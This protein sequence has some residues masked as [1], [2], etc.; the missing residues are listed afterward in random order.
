M[1]TQAEASRLRENVERLT[2]VILPQNIKCE[3]APGLC[4]SVT[5]EGGSIAAEDLSALSRGFFLAARAVKE[6]TL[7]LNVKQ[8]RHFHSVGAMVDMSRGAVMTVGAVKRYINE[9]S[10]LGMN[11]LMLYTEDT[12]EVPEYP[13]FGYL[14]GRYT[15]DELRE[16][17]AY[18]EGMGVELVP[19][20]QTLAHLAQFLQW[21]DARKLA[22]QPDVLLADDEDVYRFIEAEI[23]AVSGCIRSRRIH[24]GMDEAH[25]IGLGR[26]MEK[27]GIQDRFSILNRHLNRVMEI[28]RK[29]HYEP[30]MWSD[31]FFRLGSKINDYYDMEA[32]IP[33]SVIDMIPK[34]LE[35]CY[36]DYYHTDE[37]FYDKMLTEHAKMGKSTVFAGGNWTWTGFLP[38]L[39]KTLATMR[40]ALKAC[41]KHNID[42][43]FAT[44]W[45]DDGAETD[46][47]LASGMMPLFS[48]SCWQGAECSMDE[49]KRMSECL[50]GMSFE[51]YEAYGDFYPDNFALAPGKGLI[52]C[53][54]LYPMMNYGDE[55]FD[56]IIERS[57]MAKQKLRNYTE[58]HLECRYADTLFG[59]VIAKATLCRDLREKYLEKDRAW[60]TELVEETIPGLVE[61]YNE[62]MQLHRELWNRDMKRF[63]WEVISLRYGATKGRLEDAADEIADYL[64]GRRDS[65]PELDVLP[66]PAS[67]NGGAQRYHEFAVPSAWM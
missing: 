65:I 21:Q 1:Y 57:F 36:W 6:N 18:A 67:R 24:I 11:F 61:M 3:K 12:Y 45:G 9:L 35:M 41:A 23:A 44:L 28:C 8:E 43:V 63:G 52:W 48:E 25:G 30:M 40:P 66:L 31:M 56:Q 50:T 60:L 46:A 51:A 39:K 19:C 20:I 17:D 2:G 5:A 26:Y 10:A 58:E 15:Q 13:Y 7:P 22:D 64:A 37:A 59:V 62:L 54:P 29:Y 42:T 38:H 4:V 55:S 49:V 53:D 16:I 14:R 34:D 27:H 33:Q 32:D 47:F